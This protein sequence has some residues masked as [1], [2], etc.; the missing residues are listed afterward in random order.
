MSNLKG[1]MPVPIPPGSAAK[2]QYV[3]PD[4]PEAAKKMSFA[5]VRQVID[6]YH[7]SEIADSVNRLNCVIEN[8]TTLSAWEIEQMNKLFQ[9]FEA[10]YNNPLAKALR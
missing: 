7:S 4:M 3:R 9:K 2:D 5:E 8:G 10:K 6:A 1:S